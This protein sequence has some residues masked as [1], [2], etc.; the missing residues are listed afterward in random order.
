MKKKIQVVIEDKE[1]HLITVSRGYA[2]NYL[3]QKKNA[4]IPTKKQIKHIEMFQ[5]VKKERKK[6]NEIAIQ[7]TQKK[8]ENIGKISIYKKMGDN[9]LIFGSVTDKEITKWIIEH[10]QI[11]TNKVKIQI[12][13]IKTIGVKNISLNIKQNATHSLKV[14]IIP[15]NI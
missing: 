9:Q 14:N 12:D 2:F 13:D 6:I 11:N 3:I 1:T 15:V 4:R 7:E 8:L 5:K 10:T